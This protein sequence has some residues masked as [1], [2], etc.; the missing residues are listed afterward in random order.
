MKIH[1][2]RLRTPGRNHSVW[3][4]A[5]RTASSS[6]SLRDSAYAAQSALIHRCC[7]PG[8]HPYAEP[9]IAGDSNRATETL[10][11]AEELLGTSSDRSRLRGTYLVTSQP[12]STTSDDSG[13]V[14]SCCAPSTARRGTRPHDPPQLQRQCAICIFNADT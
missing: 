3:A 12:M 5:T 7:G 2:T 6:G 10:P 14:K 8:Q 9:W 1:S 4:N 11:S 13:S